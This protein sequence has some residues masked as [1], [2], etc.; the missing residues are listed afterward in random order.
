VDPVAGY[1]FWTD[2]SY[3]D[4]TLV[5]SDMSGANCVSLISSNLTPHVGDR[6][7]A[8]TLDPVNKLLYVIDLDT[9]VIYEVSYDQNPR[10]KAMVIHCKQWT[11]KDTCRQSPTFSALSFYDK[12]LYWVEEERNPARS[13]LNSR[14]LGGENRGEEM[15]QK[16]LDTIVG[17]LVLAPQTGWGLCLVEKQR[18]KKKCPGLCI[19]EVQFDLKIFGFLE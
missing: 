5:R 9:N 6:L 17:I 8:I 16:G 15:I 1:I 19:T 18:A 12:T 11:N 14:V 4:K 2:W 3:H 13:N 10:K 7:N